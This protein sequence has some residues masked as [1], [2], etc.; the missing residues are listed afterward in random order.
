[1][2]AKLKK[3]TKKEYSQRITGLGEEWFN[4]EEIPPNSDGTKMFAPIDKN[5]PSSTPIQECDLVF[6]G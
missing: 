3:V 4:F 2:Q 1:M 5:F 6:K